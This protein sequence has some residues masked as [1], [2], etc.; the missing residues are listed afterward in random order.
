MG[1]GNQEKEWLIKGFLVLRWVVAWI[2][3]LKKGE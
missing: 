2:W 3:V 1:S